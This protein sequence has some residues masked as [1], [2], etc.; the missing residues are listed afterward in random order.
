MLTPYKGD[1]YR[2]DAAPHLVEFVEE[3]HLHALEFPRTLEFY[4]KFLKH[5]SIADRA[6]LGAVDRYFLFTWV[7]GRKDGLHPWLYDR[8]REV[9]TAPDYHL[10][11]W[12][13]EHGKSSTISVAGTVQEIVNN[14]EITIAIFSHTKGISQR[15]V[16][17][18]RR[19]FEGNMELRQLYP[20]VCWIKP[21]T[22]API[23]TNSAFT[24][25][26]SG[27]P[28][29][30]T[31]EAHGLVDGQPTSRH[32]H[33][34]VYDDVVTRESV[35]TPEQ[36]K[37]TL[38]AFELSDNLGAGE[39]RFWV[40]GTRYSFGDLYGEIMDRDIVT[41]R[42]YPA[43]DNGKADGA[44]VFLSQEQWDKKKRTQKSQLAAQMLQNPLSGKERRFEAEWFRPWY[45][46]PTILNVYIMADPSRGRTAKS[47]R[48]AIAVVGI[49]VQNNKYLLD[50]F[51]HRMSLSQRWDALKYLHKKWSMT[52]GVGLVQV[53]YE[54][55][56]QQ[57]D[58][59]YFQER[60]RQ[61]KYSFAITELAWPREGD[62][63]KVHRVERLQPDFEYGDFYLP[64]IV[65]ATGSGDAY[66]SIDVE[67][68]KIVTR[69][70]KGDTRA[71]RE[72]KGRG[73]GYLCTKPIVRRNEENEAYDV[74]RMLMDEMLFFPFAP[75]DDLV[76]ATS[77][78]YDMD[79]VPA[80]GGDEIEE[81]EMADE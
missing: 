58:D 49:D 29:E 48:T 43:T 60:M 34:R 11:L 39:G 64:G 65:G 75:H 3:G 2:P 70:V 26:R 54:R 17:Q 76:D 53:G 80:S 24:V 30:A 28:K 66:W 37:K 9:E 15:F 61:E 6:Y 51:C 8:V 22:E 16:D 72:A 27:N 56:G 71:M 68:A 73:Q 52:I 23:W 50:G 7:L 40:I 63:S 36:M 18:I 4:A 42:I 35:S 47:D 31:V 33:L 78:I 74:T 44:P 14:P 62:H 10:D 67:E 32:F 55:Y 45:V 59:E 57:S 46:R 19:E 12:A 25:R 69:P 81:L 77:R 13:R 41:P 79:P 1:L 21:Q 5:A 20:N 38:E